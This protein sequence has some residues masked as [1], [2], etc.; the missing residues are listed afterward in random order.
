M[1]DPVFLTE[2]ADTVRPGDELDLS[3]DEG[4]HAA[5]VR[6]I[7][8]GETIVLSDGAGRGA[9]GEVIASQKSG[10]RVRVTEVLEARPP[11]LHVVCAQALAKGGHDEQAID[12][13]TQAG[14]A[15]IIPWQSARAIVRWNT[16]KAAKG[17]EKWRRI[18]REATKQSRRLR[19]PPVRDVVDTAGLASAMGEVDR[20]LVLHE[21]AED[22]LADLPLAGVGS[23]LLVVGPEGGITEDELAT[24]VGAGAHPVLVN[25]GVLRSST[26]GLVGLVQLTTLHASATA[27]APEGQETTDG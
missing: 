4:R 5:T 23:V 21:G 26:A 25:D 19:V 7:R 13:M 14:V 9:R 2:L 12:M 20:V 24:L 11:A 27:Y 8:V 18:V 6:R 17:A 22:H 3:G 16:E 15:E 1:T 10:L